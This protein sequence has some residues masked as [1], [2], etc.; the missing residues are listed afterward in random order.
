MVNYICLRNLLEDND[1]DLKHIIEYYIS[2]ISIFYCNEIDFDDELKSKI[3]DLQ[4]CINNK[5]RKEDLNV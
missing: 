5:V 1:F 3:D 4:E 2:Y